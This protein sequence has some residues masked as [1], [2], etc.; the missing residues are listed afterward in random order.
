MALTD[1]LIPT[2]GFVGS[3]DLSPTRPNSNKTRARSFARA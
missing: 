2:V 1:L 3:T